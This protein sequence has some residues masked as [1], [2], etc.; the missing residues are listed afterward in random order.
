MANNVT[1]WLVET[2]LKHTP[3]QGPGFGKKLVAEARK[4]GTFVPRA[5]GEKGLNLRKLAEGCFGPA[6]ESRLRRVSSRQEWVGEAIDAVDLSTFRDITGA[7]AVEAVEAGYAQAATVA[8]Q[9]VGTWQSPDNIFDEATIP[10]MSATPDVPENV[11]PA[12]N[13]PMAG[14]EPVWVKAPRPNKFGLIS[15]L[16]LELVKANRGSDWL[17]AN[18]EVGRAVGTDEA[19]R[20]LRVVLGITNNYNRLGTETDT[21]LTSGAYVN[22]LTDFTIT[23]GPKEY[24]RLL[25][26]AANMLHPITGKNIMFT[27]T[28]V[29]TV[30]GN[31]FSARQ[32]AQLTELRQQEAVTNT[33]TVTTISTNPLGENFP[34]MVDIMAQRL[35]DDEGGLTATQAGTVLIIAD[36]QRAF[37]WREVEPFSV[38]ETG[39]SDESW[40]PHFFQDVV[41]AVKARSWGCA[42]VR[43]PRLAYRGYKT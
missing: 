5:S 39:E 32:I 3:A 42:F 7:V 6:W 33:T 17:D 19:E 9:L 41:Y 8:N 4:K 23:N 38:Y 37:K 30:P 27:P 18:S 35:M 34:V 43:E 36:F 14:F 29:L 16:T 15:A 24:D 2:A 25:Q 10:E 1:E 40:P 11:A 21:Y 13:Y 12:T 31:A 22:S 28:A 20:K 26:L